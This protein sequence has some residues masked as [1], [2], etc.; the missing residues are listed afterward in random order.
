MAETTAMTTS[1]PLGSVN[2]A[3]CG[4]LWSQSSNPSTFIQA[5]ARFFGV[6]PAQTFPQ[7]GQIFLWIQK[8]GLESY[9][10][11][12]KKSFPFWKPRCSKQAFVAVEHRQRA[13][14][15]LNPRRSGFGDF[16]VA[17]KSS[18]APWGERCHKKNAPFGTILCENVLIGALQGGVSFLI[19]AL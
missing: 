5:L 8:V 13:A 9:G 16:R 4:C 7:E 1:N 17:Q 6:L 11:P 3:A 19:L 2:L 15:S 12:L 10:W 18:L 14:S